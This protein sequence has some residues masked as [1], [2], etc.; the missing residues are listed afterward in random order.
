V[1]QT[2]EMGGQ[3]IPAILLEAVQDDRLGGL[4]LGETSHSRQES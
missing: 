4:G 3:S 2:G 1:W